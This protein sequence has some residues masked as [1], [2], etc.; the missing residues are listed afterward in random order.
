MLYKLIYFTR[1]DQRKPIDRIAE[2]MEFIN[3]K[4]PK[5]V[6]EYILDLLDLDWVGVRQI[7]KDGNHPFGNIFQQNK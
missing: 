7:D 3:K 1:I 2:I 5:K 6:K 4:T